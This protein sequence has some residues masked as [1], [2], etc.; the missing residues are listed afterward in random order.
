MCANDGHTRSGTSDHRRQ[1][2]DSPP[3]ST[4]PQIR[5][6]ALAGIHPEKLREF[7]EAAKSQK[8]WSGRARKDHI[9]HYSQTDRKDN[10]DRKEHKLNLTNISWCDMSWN[11]VR[12]CSRVSSGCENCY[13]ERIAAR[14]SVGP[15]MDG[16]EIILRKSGPSGPF[17][18]FA[19]MTKAGPRWTGR[20]ELVKEKLD[21]PFRLK[22]GTK[23]GPLD[24]VRPKRIF[25]NSMS[26]LFHEGLSDG[27]IDEVFAV[28]AIA[29]KH[30]FLV[31]TKRANRMLDWFRRQS[32]AWKH[33][34]ILATAQNIRD[35]AVVEDWPLP[36]VWLG[37]SV[38][39][40]KTADERIPILLK[41]PAAMRFVSYEPA[42]G[43]VDFNRWLVP[44]C[45]GCG[46][47]R[48]RPVD[49]ALD[50]VI[51]GGESG[52][53][54]RPCDIGWIGAAVK[55]CNDL[56]PCFVKQLGARPYECLEG[57][58]QWKFK[59]RSGSDPSEW[60]E[61]L[62]VREFPRMKPGE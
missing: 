10:W 27:D 17:I 41:T 6:N 44:R 20:V 7:I 31:L 57:Y 45:Q 13:A 14:F 4:Q 37:V 11:P 47:Y 34:E 43:P 46:D 38:E 1:K 50:W 58:G 5:V 54:A 32:D 48:T 22:A 33:G 40:Q 39:D 19:R 24:P 12:G 35:G 8:S 15:R 53:G 23:D 29:R 21:E 3:R 60:P 36:N 42:L 16:G 62:R 49:L 52:P 25:V 9:E 55:Q 18:G 51:L 2:R 30:N 26:D 61:D 56:V 59:S 28:M